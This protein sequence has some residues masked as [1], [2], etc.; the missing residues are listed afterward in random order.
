MYVVTILRTPRIDVCSQFTVSGNGNG[1]GNGNGNGG[2]DGNGNGDGQ[3]NGN[4][5]GRN[6][7]RRRFLP[8]RALS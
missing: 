8:R 7:D 3:G 2:G 1:G 5:P 6:S 4:N